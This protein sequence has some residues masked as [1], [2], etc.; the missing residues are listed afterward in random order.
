[1]NINDAIF[2]LIPTYKRYS[3]CSHYP[4]NPTSNVIVP[5]SFFIT[6]FWQQTVSGRHDLENFLII[7]YLPYSDTYWKVAVGQDSQSY[8]CNVV[9]RYVVHNHPNKQCLIKIRVGYCWVLKIIS[10]KN[11]ACVSLKL[12][13]ESY[14]S[15]P[16]DLSC[17]PW[18]LCVNLSCETVSAIEYSV[19][20]SEQCYTLK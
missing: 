2:F 14:F 7:N 1:M 15:R 16:G 9:I 20:S 11:K 19:I 10:N 12:D 8:K 5:P 4:E 6:N 17:N 3:C 13:K 18:L